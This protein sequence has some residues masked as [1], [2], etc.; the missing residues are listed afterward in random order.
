MD[1]RVRNKSGHTGYLSLASHADYVMRLFDSPMMSCI[2]FNELD[3]LN[4]IRHFSR[5]FLDKDVNF[6]NQ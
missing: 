6:E 1:N 3:F 4:S 2:N 5:I